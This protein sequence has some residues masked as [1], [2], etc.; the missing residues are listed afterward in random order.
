MKKSDHAKGYKRSS[1]VNT[2]KH[3][4]TKMAKASRR[5]NAA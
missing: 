2:R 5:R 1:K 3:I 4:R